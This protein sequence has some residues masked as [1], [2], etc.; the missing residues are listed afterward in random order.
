[1]WVLTLV[2]TTLAFL[3]GLRGVLFVV[4]HGFISC[5]GSRTVVELLFPFHPQS[6]SRRVC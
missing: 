2:S 3:F 4:A 6:G 5:L 1:L